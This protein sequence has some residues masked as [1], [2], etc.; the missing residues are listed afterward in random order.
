M[1]HLR[2]SLPLP[3]RHS[4]SKQSLGRYLVSLKPIWNILRFYLC[5]HGKRYHNHCTKGKHFCPLRGHNRKQ[6]W[7]ENCLNL[8]PLTMVSFYNRVWNSGLPSFSFQGVSFP[9]RVPDTLLIMS[10]TVTWRIF[11]EW[12]NP[13]LRI[14]SHHW[15]WVVLLFT[16]LV[17]PLFSTGHVY[18]SYLTH[19]S[20]AEKVT[21]FIALMIYRKLKDYF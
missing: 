11:T 9:E 14:H 1:C 17:Y 12:N 21:W 16:R 7:G 10:Q 15:F 19:F 2:G 4:G 5:A 20:R 3:D 8:I 13:L 6:A 18:L